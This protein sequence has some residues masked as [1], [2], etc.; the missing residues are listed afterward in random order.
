MSNSNQTNRRTLLKQTGT[1]LGGGLIATTTASASHSE[2]DYIL[3]S[4]DYGAYI[5]EDADVHS[6]ILDKAAPSAKGY[7]SAT[8]YDPD[9]G[10]DMYYVNE[11]E[12]LADYP[13]GWVAEYEVDTF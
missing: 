9:S 6:E 4:K 7:V 3:T 5:Y 2:P 1:L 8:G 10:V 11:W 12:V 13:T